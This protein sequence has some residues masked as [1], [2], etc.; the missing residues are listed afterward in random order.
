MAG[1]PLRTAPKAKVSVCL[2]V[3]DGEQFL[4][5]AI[6]SVLGQTFA[7]LELLISDDDSSD[8]SWDVIQ[9]YAAQDDRVK[10]A[11]ALRRQG[12]FAN[13]NRC[14]ER[15]QGIYTKFFAQDDVL[16][17]EHLARCVDVLNRHS[18]VVLV[19]TRRQWINEHDVD[20]SD[21][22]GTP[23]S[24]EFLP[25]ATPIRSALVLEKSLMPVV[26]FIGEPSTVTIRTAC[27]DSGFDTSFRQ[28]GDLEYWLRVLGHGNYYFIDHILCKFRVHSSSETQRNN[29][30]LYFAPDLLKIGQKFAAHLQQLGYSPEAFNGQCLRAIGA[31]LEH[32]NGTEQISM[33]DLRCSDKL[34]ALSKDSKSVTEL[35]SDFLSFRELACYALLELQSLTGQ[36]T[37]ADPGRAPDAQAQAEEQTRQ[38]VATLE[39]TVKSLL[40]SSSWRYT[41]ILRE[42]NRTAG[43][44]HT[45][46]CVR[47]PDRSVLTNREEYV[48]YLRDTIR[49]VVGS[50]SWKLTSPMRA[51]GIDRS[52]PL[53]DANLESSPS[54]RLF[55][56]EY[57]LSENPSISPSH[58]QDPLVHF[59]LHGGR[60]GLDPHVLFDSKFYRSTY[61]DVSDANVVP[62]LHYLRNGVWENRNPHPL[63]DSEFYMSQNPDVGK[64]DFIPLL[65]YLQHGAPAGLD[66]HQLFDTAYYMKQKPD[67]VQYGGN[68]LIHYLR[69]GA[70]LGFNPNP[71]FDT[72][73]YA[74]QMPDSERHLNPLV[75]YVTTG[76]ARGLDPGPTF[77]TSYY[78]LTNPDIAQAGLNPLTHY[79]QIGQFE[80]RIGRRFQTINQAVQLLEQR[81]QFKTA[82]SKI[83]ELTSKPFQH[84]V[85][86]GSLTRGGSE[87]SACSLVTALQEQ[88]GRDNV[89]ML[90]TDRNEVTCRDWLPV[91]TR[92]INFFAVEESLTADERSV[93]LL[94]ILK[95]CRPKTAIAVIS[96]IFW[97][98]L[99]CHRE[100]WQAEISSKV[101]SYLG[102]YEGF[103]HDNQYGFQSGFIARCVSSVDLFLPDNQRLRDAMVE[104]FA[105]IPDIENRVRTCYFPLT[106]ELHAL[107]SD[108]RPVPAT[109][110][111]PQPVVLWASR[112]HKQKQPH[113]L[114][115]IAERMP[116]IHFEVWGNESPDLDISFLRGRSNISLMGEYRDFSALPVNDKALFL[117]TSSGDGMPNVLVEA[118]A[119][120]LPIVSPNVGG[121]SELIDEESGWLVSPC[122]D[123]DAYV[124]AIRYIVSHPHEARQRGLQV[125]A[126]VAN[127]YS[128]SHFATHLRNLIAETT[129][130]FPAVDPLLISSSTAAGAHY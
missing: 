51:V 73:F 17:P 64:S 68:P 118:A 125:Q 7:D 78:L 108:S 22:V 2:P 98:T 83:R 109:V 38:L 53:G 123:I 10:P 44:S 97:T 77:N 33:E 119:C 12:L 115:A 128:W 52:L 82:L 60:Q 56:C 34:L 27:R 30:T 72:A 122:D 45:T 102:G 95:R 37:Q 100:I 16:H 55:D 1:T 26:N 85:V 50:L 4:A 75:H 124:T 92:F 48:A 87:R 47:L 93:L 35:L 41:R 11:R 107:L 126:K 54:H 59:L 96:A 89:V 117:H 29:R 88:C 81:V 69:V 39:R 28:L 74:H 130:Q 105:H 90:L 5:S 116:D 61:K 63:F 24:Q 76:A 14:L 121:I 101:A 43:I 127:H 104:R 94:E 62:L 40:G 21:S 99:D 58:S 70:Q 103:V 6:E 111:P 84:L 15:A 120:G 79:L 106:R 86:L 18:D 31:H 8:G 113:I 49:R 65:H 42:I 25:A 46:G 71:L 3:F 36:P 57:Y 80:P 91:G 112:L 13:Y 19:S 9:H 110:A 67:L 23:D 20:I 32:L 129:S 66:P 114:S